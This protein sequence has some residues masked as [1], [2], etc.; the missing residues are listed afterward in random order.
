[1]A[2]LYQ[3]D[4]RVSEI[5]PSSGIHWTEDELRNLVGGTPEIVRTV[6]GGFMVINDEGKILT[7]PLELN[8]PATRLYLHGRSDV[9][10]GPAVVVDSRSELEDPGA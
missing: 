6:D 5:R 2:L 8:I 7:P 1:M 4:G 3:T 9:I 10:L